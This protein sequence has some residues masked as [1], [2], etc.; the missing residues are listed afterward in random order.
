MRD[1]ILMLAVFDGHN[2]AL[3]NE[4]HALFAQGRPE[5]HLDLP[6]MRAGGIRGGIFAIFTPSPGESHEPL[7][8]D[9]GVIEFEY[10]R[11]IRR[12]R[13]AAHATACAGRLH[14]LER[15]GHVRVARGIADVDRA[16]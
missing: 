7:P 1:P 16:L 2:D 3:T 10:A 11:T 9:D 14:E 4:D 5:G 15:E 12:D 8:R 6:K 13:A